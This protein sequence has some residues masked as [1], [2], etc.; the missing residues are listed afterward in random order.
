MVDMR[1]LRLNLVIDEILYHQ[2]QQAQ[3]EMERRSN[4]PYLLISS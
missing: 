2:M 4:W 1:V 3:G